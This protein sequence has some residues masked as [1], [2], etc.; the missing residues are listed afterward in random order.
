MIS[1][2]QEFDSHQFR[3]DERT[4]LSRMFSMIL[5][6]FGKSD[7]GRNSFSDQNLLDAAKNAGADELSQKIIADLCEETNI[8]HETLAEFIED[9]PDSASEWTKE[10]LLKLAKEQNPDITD[11]EKDEIIK[12]LEEVVEKMALR[13]VES[14]GVESHDQISDTDT[15]AL[16]KLHEEEKKYNIS[17][18]QDEE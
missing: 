14:L 2:N 6:F 12:E 5:A 3:S 7:N 4:L 8:Y 10:K 11:A 15:E 13:N 17:L 9:S 18:T 16:I 1:Q